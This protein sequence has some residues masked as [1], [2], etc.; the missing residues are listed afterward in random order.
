[1]D[2]EGSRGLHLA[3]DG[4]WGRDSLLPSAVYKTQSDHTTVLVKIQ[5]VT[6]QHKRHKWGKV[7]K[8]KD[9]KTGGRKEKLEDEIK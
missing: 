8:E 2:R 6:K 5:S 7:L 3:I 9:G 4:F 1:M